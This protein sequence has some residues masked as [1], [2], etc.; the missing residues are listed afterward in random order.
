[1]R[2]WHP[3]WHRF[4][5]GRSWSSWEPRLRP[6]VFPEEMRGRPLSSVHPLTR[7]PRLCP[8]APRAPRC[9]HISTRPRGRSW[10]CSP[11][12][13]RLFDLIGCSPDE[14]SVAG[15]AVIFSFSAPCPSF[16][17][18]IIHVRHYSHP[19]LFTFIITNIHHCSHPSLLVFV[20]VHIRHY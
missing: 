11:Y 9:R 4:R 15:S 8:L 12:P 20:I 16:T 17:S 3:A 2:R 1:M 18:V 6:R 19:S 13:A 5:T 14:D 10:R 7:H